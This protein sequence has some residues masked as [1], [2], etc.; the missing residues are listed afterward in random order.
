MVC[1]QYSKTVLK[2]CIRYLYPR[3]SGNFQKFYKFH[4][5][6][7][8]WR[9]SGSCL[10]LFVL[11]SILSFLCCSFSTFA[12]IMY[13]CTLVA[14]FDVWMYFPCLLLHHT[15]FLWRVDV[16]SVS[17]SA[18]YLLPVTCGCIFRVF[19]CIILASCDVWMYLPCLLTL[20]PNALWLPWFY[21]SKIYC[22]LKSYFTVI[23]I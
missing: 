12:Y 7:T 11:V 18:S 21:L 4:I 23:L 1:V 14:S 5:K 20:L 3:F 6:Y 16:S 15:C 13:Y 10:F 17:S 8:C 2:F 19:F 9:I 22:I